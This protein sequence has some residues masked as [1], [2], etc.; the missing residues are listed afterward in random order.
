MAIHQFNGS[1]LKWKEDASATEITFKLRNWTEDQAE[2]T[3]A[4]I[5]TSTDSRREFM[6]GLAGECVWNTEIIMDPDTTG[7][8]YTDWHSWLGDCASGTL[9]FQFISPACSGTYIKLTADAWLKGFSI[10]GE[11]D[12]SLIINASWHIDSFSEGTA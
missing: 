4:D 1:I 9:T 3:F 2:R 12:E 5:T 7:A 10:V 6:P 11:I 8:K